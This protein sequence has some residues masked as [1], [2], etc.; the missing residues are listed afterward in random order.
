MLYVSIQPSQSPLHFTPSLNPS[1]YFKRPVLFFFSPSVLL[2]TRSFFSVATE[3]CSSGNQCLRLS[4][5]G[6]SD[7][8]SLH[9]R[10]F[11]LI[12]KVSSRPFVLPFVCGCYY[13]SEPVTWS[14]SSALRHEIPADIH[15]QEYLETHCSLSHS[16]ST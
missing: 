16:H 3:S 2:I 12:C 13:R 11:K 8:A 15:F 7:E 14:V 9:F 10:V 1:S 5:F 4:A 6:R